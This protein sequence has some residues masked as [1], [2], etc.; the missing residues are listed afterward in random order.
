MRRAASEIRRTNERRMYS[1]APGGTLWQ[2]AKNGSDGDDVRFL[3]SR[4]LLFLS[5]FRF[6]LSIT[7]LRKKRARC[8]R[9]ARAAL[10]ICRTNGRRMYSVAPGGRLWQLADDGRDD[11]D[12]RRRPF[13]AS[14]LLLF[15]CF[16]V[17][18]SSIT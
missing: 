8:M 2:S 13:F 9:Q 15:L 7:W 10:E 16:L 11:D 5:V 1:V 4:L 17:F 14:R 3:A 18:V 12:H 6:V